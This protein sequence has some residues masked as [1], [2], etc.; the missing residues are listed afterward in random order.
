[1]DVDQRRGHDEDDD[2]DGQM[3]QAEVNPRAIA[4][5]VTRVEPHVT[6][7]REDTTAR[8]AGTVARGAAV[9]TAAPKPKAPARRPATATAAAANED[10][11]PTRVQ[12]DAE[13][14]VGDRDAIQALAQTMQE[15]M[16][17][18]AEMHATE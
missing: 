13:T 3:G 8:S 10:R 5:G 15:Q 12:A 1:M 11:H 6:R 18:M 17:F 2:Q 14:T 7:Q 16:H 4:R 9:A